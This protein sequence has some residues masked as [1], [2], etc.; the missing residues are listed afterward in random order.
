MKT[1][2]NINDVGGCNNLTLN[3]GVNNNNNK[4]NKVF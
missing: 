3:S 2:V 1:R 4:I